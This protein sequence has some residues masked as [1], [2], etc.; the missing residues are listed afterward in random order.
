M[1]YNK[2][3]PQSGD[4]C[5]TDVEY[6]V[7]VSGNK[8]VSNNN[9]SMKAAQVPSDCGNHFSLDEKQQPVLEVKEPKDK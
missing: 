7:N 1:S 5:G 3:N 2:S 4:H 9:Y 8:V 6:P